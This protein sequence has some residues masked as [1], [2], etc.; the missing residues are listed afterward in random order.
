[1]NLTT[2]ADRVMIFCILASIAIA[3]LLVEARLADW[4][5]DANS[6]VKKQVSLSS[7]VQ[8]KELASHIQIGQFLIPSSS[9][10]L[11]GQ[12]EVTDIDKR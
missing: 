3:D 1:M 6:Q 7:Y 8:S 10:V 11:S 2:N 5:E 4:R 12:G 9:T